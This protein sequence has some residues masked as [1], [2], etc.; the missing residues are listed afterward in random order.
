[1]LLFFRISEVSLAKRS[2][3]KF[4]SSHCTIYVA[5]SKRDA[6]RQGNE[7]MLARTGRVTSPVTL[8]ERFCSVAVISENS[9]E[10]LFRPVFLCKHLNK[11]VLRTPYDKPLSYT[12]VSEIL[13]EKLTV[14]GYDPTKFGLHSFRSGAASASAS[15]GTN[16]RLWQKH[17][18]WKSTAA[19]GGYVKDSL[20]DRL[21]FTLDLGV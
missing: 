21:S 12:R 20:Q 18:R 17:G 3:I 5:K 11:Y 10:H 9:S 8:L 4:Y 7:V 14:L 1:M 19:R 6:L 16:E 2:D 13:K 15:S